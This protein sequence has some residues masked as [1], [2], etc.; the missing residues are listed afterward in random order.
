MDILHVVKRECVASSVTAADKA[1]IIH[2]I[3][4]LA[5]AVPALAGVT[6]GD[7][8]QGL[9]EREGVGTTGFGKGIAIPHC[10]LKTRSDI[11]NIA[12]HRPRRCRRV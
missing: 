12:H 2:E 3:A 6:E 1:A 9:L 5:A 7:I 11:G 4:R 8:E 10:R